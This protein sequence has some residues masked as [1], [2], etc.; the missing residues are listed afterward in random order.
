MALAA[1]LFLSLICAGLYHTI[2]RKT[3]S[4]TLFPV[5][6]ASLYLYSIGGSPSMC[7]KSPVHAFRFVLVVVLSKPPVLHFSSLYIIF[8]FVLFYI[9]PCFFFPSQLTLNHPKL[10]CTTRRR[11]LTFLLYIQCKS[12]FTSSSSFPFS[13]CIL[14]GFIDF[15]D[16]ITK[17]VEKYTVAFTTPE[18]GQIFDPLICV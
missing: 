13:S 11:I 18:I 10:L 16:R 15:E 2:Q 14:P 8:V 4:L 7:L 9:S 3:S 5:R 6:S 1:L 17:D 12:P